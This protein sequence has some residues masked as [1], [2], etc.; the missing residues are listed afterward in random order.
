MQYVPPPLRG[1]TT[2]PGGQTQVKVAKLQLL[3]M[4]SAIPAH[5]LLTWHLAQI[6]PPQSMSLSLPFFTPSE[7][8]G[9]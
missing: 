9:G 3:L 6:E 1:T 2:M 7:H 5:L 8:V 4:Q